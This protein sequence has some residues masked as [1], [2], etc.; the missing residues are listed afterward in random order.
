MN[1]AQYDCVKARAKLLG[2][3]LIEMASALD[4]EICHTHAEFEER[5]NGNVWIRLAFEGRPVPGPDIETAVDTLDAACDVLRTTGPM[6]FECVSWR[7]D[8]RG[9]LSLRETGFGLHFAA[10]ISAWADAS[11]PVENG[12]TLQAD[13]TLI[14]DASV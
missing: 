9:E 13:G 1:D 11:S 8:D 14:R 12:W 6:F 2:N 5:F 3:K 10:L 4:L 7:R